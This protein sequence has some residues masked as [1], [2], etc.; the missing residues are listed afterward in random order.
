MWVAL[1]DVGPS[2]SFTSR[3][4][5]LISMPFQGTVRNH[6]HEIDRNVGPWIN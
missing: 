5:V 6:F 1:I 4:Y 3:L 2:V